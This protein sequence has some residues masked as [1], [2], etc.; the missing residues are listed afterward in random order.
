[1][2]YNYLQEE[3]KDIIDYIKN[4]LTFTN[5]LNLLASGKQSG[6]QQ[7]TEELNEKLFNVDSVTGNGSGSYTFNTLQAERNLVGNW[8]ILRTAIDELDPSFDAIHKGA[9]ACDVL[10]R[11]YLLPTAIDDAITKLWKKD[12]NS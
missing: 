9:E 5:R 4:E 6:K 3:T 1:M 8:E 2:T 12:E 10:V 7:A 11:I